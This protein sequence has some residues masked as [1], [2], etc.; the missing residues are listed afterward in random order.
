M[1]GADTEVK[2]GPTA[3]PVRPFVAGSSV[4]PPCG[5]TAVRNTL[6]PLNYS[7]G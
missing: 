5:V 7:L 2:L 3:L 1:L 6:Y 4:A